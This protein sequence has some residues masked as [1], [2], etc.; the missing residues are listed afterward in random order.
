ALADDPQTTSVVVVSKPPDDAVLA[1]IESYAA[2]LGVEV[3]WAILGQG[4]PDLTAAVESLLG[5]LGEA[6]PD[7]PATVADPEPAELMRGVGLRGLLC[8]G[9]LAD[10]AMIVATELLGEPIRSNITHD[11]DL[12]VSGHDRVEGHLIVDFGDDEM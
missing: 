5:A 4:R 3:H 10:E 9:T 2:D 8:G 1:D 11:A 12:R 6:V 7:W